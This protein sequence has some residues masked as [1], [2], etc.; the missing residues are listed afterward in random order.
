MSY[1]TQWN[2]YGKGED[3][4]PFAASERGP[5]CEALSEIAD[6][7]H[8]QEEQGEFICA[9][10]T[11]H[12]TA[13]ANTVEIL[14]RFSSDNPDTIVKLE[15]HN[16]DEDWRQIILFQAGERRCGSTMTAPCPALML[17]TSGSTGFCSTV[18]CFRKRTR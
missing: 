1:Y 8:C 7:W 17:G 18:T 5:L 6:E 4:K 3:G 11:D 13:Y 14:M 15:C 12:S 9:F 2:L 16:E 10:M